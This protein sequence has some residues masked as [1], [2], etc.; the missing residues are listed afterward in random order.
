M[1]AMR[2]PEPL[3]C[4]HC[5]RR[6]RWRPNHEAMPCPECGGRLR[7]QSVSYVRADRDDSP[8]ADLA[9]EPLP[10]EAQP[11]P[12]RPTMPVPTSTGWTTR[13]LLLLGVVA[14]LAAV[15]VIK[16]IANRADSSSGSTRSSATRPATAESNSKSAAKRNRPP[17]T[18]VVHF[19]YASRNGYTYDITMDSVGL[20]EDVANASPGSKL[21]YLNGNFGAKVTNTT[22]GRNAPALQFTL[23]VAFPQA[24]PNCPPGQGSFNTMRFNAVDTL[25]QTET[26]RAGSS[27]QYGV[28]SDFARS[29]DVQSIGQSV[30]SRQFYWTVLVRIEDY[31][32]YE[33]TKQYQG[34]WHAAGGLPLAKA[35]PTR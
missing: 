11:R 6:F 16:E 33:E 18:D 19:S 27:L 10:L 1:K 21:I 14:V 15:P 9:D 29:H 26:I 2:E 23:V 24:C 35:P 31:A 32:N 34:G 22:A 25:D 4:G 12:V 20:A 28:D 7:P 17:P 5:G 13:K 30:D 3:V 8:F